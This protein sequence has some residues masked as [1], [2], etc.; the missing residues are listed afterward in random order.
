MEETL[1]IKQVAD[2]L[3]MDYQTVFKHRFRWGFFRME[4]SNVWRITKSGLEKAQ[5]RSNNADRLA[6]S[7]EEVKLCRSTKEKKVTT[8]GLISQPRVVKELDTLLARM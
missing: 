6:L 2:Y 8:G 4:G 3:Q 7:V 5:K 1:T